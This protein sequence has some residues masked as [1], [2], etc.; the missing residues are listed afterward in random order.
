MYV[1]TY[2]YV[3]AFQSAWYVPIVCQF[4]FGALGRDATQTTAG[5]GAPRDTR[6]LTK[7]QALGC[8]KSPVCH[9]VSQAPWTRLARNDHQLEDT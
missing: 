1:W 4:S 5:L 6:R 2:M 3:S 8:L 7:F 9:G